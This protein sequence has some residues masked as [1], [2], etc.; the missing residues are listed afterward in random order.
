MT[1]PQV[2]MCLQDN[3]D[4]SLWKIVGEEYHY[5]EHWL[6]IRKEL[7]LELRV[8]PIGYI[9]HSYCLVEKCPPTLAVIPP[10]WSLGLSVGDCVSY[11]YM[12]RGK[13]KTQI[14]QITKIVGD[15]ATIE[16]SDPS[17]PVRGRV[18]HDLYDLSRRPAKDCETREVD[19][20][21]ENPYWLTISELKEGCR[22]KGLSASGS[23]EDL[24]RRLI[25]NRLF[26]K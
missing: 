1:E 4:K 12:Q 25:K 21:E 18:W 26:Q 17:F 24:V 15:E 7:T 14:G 3:F 5:N 11:T 8:I 6:K 20:G 13:V 22:S 19:K 9:P 16:I 23:K 2:G 10:P